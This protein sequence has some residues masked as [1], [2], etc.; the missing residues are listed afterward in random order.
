[1]NNSLTN[2]KKRRN[3]SFKSNASDDTTTARTTKRKVK[4]PR[5]S[6]KEELNVEIPSDVSVFS[7]IDSETSSSLVLSNEEK[8]LPPISSLLLYK[9]SIAANRFDPFEPHVHYILP[10]PALSGYVT[11]AIVK[12]ESTFN[13][14]VPPVMPIIPY[15]FHHAQFGI[16]ACMNQLEYHRQQHSVRAYSSN[17]VNNG[18]NY[19]I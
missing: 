19:Y 11:P 7:T 14:S 1:M 3:S 4:K 18:V 9:P 16:E 8:S 10:G 6:V 17:S 15:Y 5:V 12:H 13:A 2:S